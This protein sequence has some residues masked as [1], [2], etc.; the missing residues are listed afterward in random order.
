MKDLC[1]FTENGIYCPAGDFF[2]DPHKPVEKAVITHAHADHARFGSKKYLSNTLNNHILRL[3]LGKDIDLSTMSYGEQKELNGVKISFHPAGHIWGSSQVRLEYKGEVWVIAGDYKV[4]DDGF[5]GVFEPVKCH[6]FITE[7]TFA[8]PVFDWKPQSEVIED[9]NNW[10]LK[11]QAE[12]KVSILCAYSL[13]K[14][15]RLIANI[16]HSIGKVFVHGAI[17]NVNE[18]LLASGA[19]LPKT[20]YVESEMNKNQYSGQ[21][22]IAPS[23]AIGTSWVRKFKPFELATVSG[24]MQIRGIKQRR[25]AGH[26]FVLSDHADWKGLN[27]AIK[28]TQAERVIV[29]HGYTDIYSRW[30]AEQGYQSQTAES[31]FLP[32]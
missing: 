7:S 25:N 18:A 1:V 27:E 15:Q 30:L 14:A 5:S 9:I 4:E 20:F 6:T 26:G 29:N 19:V 32:A 10:W 31:L 13:G 11:N 17:H 8:L 23:S 28:S 24:W 3:R 12:N 2:I 21:M 22:V 16:D